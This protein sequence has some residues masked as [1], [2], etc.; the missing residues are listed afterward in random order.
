MFPVAA[1]ALLLAAL[2]CFPAADALRVADRRPHGP[3]A[4]VACRGVSRREAGA[5]RG[6]PGT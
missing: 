6:L 4:G 3:G 1:G 5:G 2:P